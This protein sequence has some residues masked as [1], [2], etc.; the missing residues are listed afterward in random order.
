[1]GDP[2][3]GLGPRRKWRTQWVPQLRAEGAN[4]AGEARLGEASAKADPSRGSAWRE[5]GET[6]VTLREGT[7]RTSTGRVRRPK[8]SAPVVLRVGILL[9]VPVALLLAVTIGF[10]GGQG[11]REGNIEPWV[12]ESSSRGEREAVGATRSSTSKALNG[13]GTTDERLRGSATRSAQPSRNSASHHREPPR[14]PAIA[15]LPPLTP[16]AQVETEEGF[17]FER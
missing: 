2:R 5:E 10:H 6:A 11:N 7:S 17:G 16:A 13:L 14:G 3:I 15:D 4:P 1:M 12:E 9:G 8:Q